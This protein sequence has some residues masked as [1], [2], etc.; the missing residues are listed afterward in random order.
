MAVSD[1]L[2]EVWASHESSVSVDQVDRA[3][4]AAG[5][6][7]VV[8]CECAR[9]LGQITEQHLRTHDMTLAEYK[10]T[11]PDAPI[12]PADTA[13]QPGRDPGFSH[14]E[15]TKRKIAERTK[16]NHKRGFYK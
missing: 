5:D 14:S 15:A 3:R 6:D 16:Q 2:E 10:T 13:R 1:S 12:Y 4:A 8:C 11:H 7:Q 9:A